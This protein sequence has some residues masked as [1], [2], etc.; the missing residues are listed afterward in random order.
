M[1][2]P[3]IAVIG[4]GIGGLALA[5]T[6]EEEAERLGVPLDLAVFE[7]SAAAG[8]H[9]RTIEDDGFLVEGGP[10]GFLDREPETLALVRALGLESRLVEARPEAKRRFIVRGARLCRVPESPPTLLTS[11]ALSLVGKL[12]L[13]M[14]PFARRAPEGV[15]ETIF[16]FARRRIGREAA[17]MLVDAAVSGISAGDSRVLSVRAQFPLMV[18]MEREHGGLIKAM[19]ARRRRGITAPRLLSFDRGLATLTRA[20]ADRLGARLRTATRVRSIQ[21]SGAAWRLALAGGGTADADQVVLA[22]SAKVAADLVS[23]VDRELAAALGGI[24]YS[25]VNLVA[26]AFKAE[27]VPRALDGYG[28]L[29]TRPERLATLGVVW[30][31]SL[32]PGRAPSGMALL[33]VFLGGARRPDAA[34]LDEEAAVRL[35]R[36]ELARV[37]HVRADPA[38]AWTFRWPDAIAQYTIG[39]LDRV[40]AIRDRLRRH[41]GLEVCGASYDG[42]SFNHAIASGRRTARSLAARLVREGAYRRPSGSDEPA[43][44]VA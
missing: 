11:K 39:H 2:R 43:H 40:A 35:A 3:R 13:L 15:D 5:F 33:R 9:A 23:G 8:G 31:S 44:A 36:A 30:E 28:Y 41:D 4:A 38:R 32:F 12:R 26:L 14:E 7:A 25:G 24:T 22:V 1:T 34:W 17:E 6:L 19:I 42:V 18:E 29:V 16:D 10:N 27:D 37:M 20:L 21:R